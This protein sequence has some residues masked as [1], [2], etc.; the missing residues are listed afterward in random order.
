[1]KLERALVERSCAPFGINHTI[2]HSRP[3][4]F[5]KFEDKFSERI[6]IPYTN[7]LTHKA[8]QVLICAG[9]YPKPYYIYLI[10]IY[11]SPV[12][13]EEFIRHLL[14]INP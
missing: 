12:H 1:M 13:Q 8:N 14:A 4:T 2:L 3:H 5:H 10:Y 9:K 11:I 7:I 6:D